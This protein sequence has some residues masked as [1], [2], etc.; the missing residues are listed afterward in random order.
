MLETRRVNWIRTV[1][2]SVP[3]SQPTIFSKASPVRGNI[4]ADYFTKITSVSPSIKGEQLWNGQS[5][6]I[7]VEI[8]SSAIKSR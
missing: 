5:N 8:R 4:P 7:S 2:S 1:F 6:L 3:G